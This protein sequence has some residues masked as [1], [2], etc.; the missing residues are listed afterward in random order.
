MNGTSIVRHYKYK[1]IAAALAALL[2]VVVGISTS[3]NSDTKSDTKKISEN[4][5]LSS[6]SSDTSKN[7]QSQ[8]KFTKSYKYETVNNTELNTGNLVLVS[9]DHPYSGTVSDT[10]GVYSYLF[11]SDGNQIMYASNT[12]IVAKKEVLQQF[13][14]L[15]SAFYSET[16]L[17]SLMINEALNGTLS[18]DE[19][20]DENTNETSEMDDQTSDNATGL[21]IDLRL[22][23]AADGTYPD[24][25]G[26]DQYSWIADNG[27]EYGFVLRYPKD[28]VKVTGV[29]ADPSHFRYVGLPFAEIMHE[30]S[31]ALEELNDY[32]KS[33]TFEK[34][35]T[36]EAEDGNEYIIYYVQ[37]EKGDST[38]IPVPLNENKELY[39]YTLSGNNIDGYVICVNT[40]DDSEEENDYQ[41][42]LL[43]T[44]EE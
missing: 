8:N 6:S 44:S 28:K 20:S 15:A 34:P 12:E 9:K 4:I 22:Y 27:W 13:N 26:E 25:T 7:E 17:S 10:D 39:P 14:K 30:K 37:M 40:Y 19:N 2:L 18:S 36:F 1:N 31:F 38:N 24:F 29:D 41:Q 16:G 5:S 23:N 32:L 11:N 21:S 35:L 42:S 3:C 33:Y 43:S